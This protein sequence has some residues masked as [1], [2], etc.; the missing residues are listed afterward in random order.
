M[1]LKFAE[2]FFLPKNN[3]HHGLRLINALNALK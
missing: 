3:F 2:N 1:H